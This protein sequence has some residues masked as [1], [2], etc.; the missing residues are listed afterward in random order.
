MNPEFKECL[1]RRKIILF[2]GGKRLIN[3]ELRSAQQDLDDADFGLS[4]GRHKWPTIQGYYSMYH[5]A[6]ALLFSQDYREK[7]HYCLYAALKALFVEPGILDIKF[8]DAFYHA[9]ILRENA[10]Y[11]SKFT[12]AGATLV[13]ERAREFLLEAKEILQFE[14]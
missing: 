8:A 7:S 6:R 13:L 14:I 12:R 11:R 5:T 10:D 9:M 4:H 2:S 1:K 3:K